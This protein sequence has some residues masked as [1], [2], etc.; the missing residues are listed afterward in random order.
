MPPILLLIDQLMSDFAPF[1][2]P[3]HVAVAVSGGPDSM[4]LARALHLWTKRHQGKLTAFHVD[5]QLRPTSTEEARIVQT[6]LRE[7]G[8]DSSILTWAHPPLTS[9][10]MNRARTARYQ[11]LLDACQAQGILHLAVAHH[12]DDDQ[13]TAWMRQEK[14]SGP[15]GL[16]GMS[17]VIDTPH[18]RIIRPF[19]SLSKAHLKEFL[20]DWPHLDDPS[21]YNPRFKRGHIR[22]TD[23]SLNLIDIEFHKNQR[24]HNERILAQLSVEGVTLF[25]SGYGLLSSTVLETA[26]S[27]VLIEIIRRMVRTIGG[28]SYSPSQDVCQ[29]LFSHSRTSHFNR[30]TLG[31]CVLTFTKTGLV[32]TRELRT[33]KPHLVTS[34]TP[35]QWDQRFFVD[36]LPTN[37]LDLGMKL[38]YLGV[39]GFLRV[40]SAYPLSMPTWIGE[41]LPAMWHDD[42]IIHPFFSLASD[43]LPVRLRFQPKNP[44]LDAH[45]ATTAPYGERKKP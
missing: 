28:H 26:P 31:G 43:S 39:K 21:N 1:E 42:Q 27:H 40:R 25:P 10:L 20:H 18:T 33:V 45:F 3:P 17:A 35:F 8:I 5:H 22:T 13:E 9:G 24:L 6:W 2:H 11:L 30:A 41:S 4:A 19:L 23:A 38:N 34:S 44:F 32:V 29:R 12:R 36:H 15:S 16:A 7:R 37:A 14:K